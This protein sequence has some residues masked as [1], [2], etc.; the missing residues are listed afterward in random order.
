MLVFKRTHHDYPASRIGLVIRATAFHR[1][2]VPLEL[3]DI[4]RLMSEGNWT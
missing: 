1:S 2:R 4:K 3:A